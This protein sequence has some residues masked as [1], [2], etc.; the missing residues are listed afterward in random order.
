MLAVALGLSSSLCWGLADFFG[1]LQSRKRAALAVLLVSQG[2]ALALL[3]PF[4]LDRRRRAAVGRSGGAGPR[5][6]ARPASSPWAP[7]TARW[8]S[9][10]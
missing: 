4:A 10:R 8:R 3:I 9:G 5:S 1:G 2:V 7:S 6:R